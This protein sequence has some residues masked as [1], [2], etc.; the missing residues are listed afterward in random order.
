MHTD[1]KTAASTINYTFD[2]SLTSRSSPIPRLNYGFGNRLF[3]FHVIKFPGP[4]ETHLLIRVDQA[5]ACWS[6]LFD[7]VRFLYQNLGLARPQ[8][9]FP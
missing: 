7:E 9:F 3:A 4:V 8:Y 1:R 6:G 5:K 2:N